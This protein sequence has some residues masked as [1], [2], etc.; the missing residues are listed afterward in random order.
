MLS[1][2]LKSLVK[3]YSF[4]C[5]GSLPFA[6][7]ERACEFV[8]SHESILPFWPELPKASPHQFMLSRSE[9]ASEP[10][11]R[12]YTKEEA[13][14]FFEFVGKMETLPVLKCQLMGPV[15]YLKYS[16]DN[17]IFSSELFQRAV[18]IAWRQMHWQRQQIPM[19]TC[20]I[21]VLDEPVIGN[22]A[23]W[24]RDEVFEGYSYLY[25]R[26]SELNSYIGVHICGK[27]SE[28]VFDL[29]VQ[30]ISYTH[31]DLCE[32]SLQSRL[33]R[34]LS[35]GGIIAPGFVPGVPPEGADMEALVQKGR[36]EY[37]RLKEAFSHY[38]S[39][40]LF[41]ADC[42]HFGADEGW[43]KAIYG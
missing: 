14:G 34:F 40:L 32:T 42:G 27:L 33:K 29:P 31:N 37:E 21:F 2:P 6:Q 30:L 43:L 15:S 25:A 17:V 38:A 3:P 28:K 22:D 9:R 26:I 20:I 35:D 8:L 7:A 4:F 5:V 10:G 18:Q 24:H 39:Q 12:G 23:Y 13:S 19:N 11:W 36:D 16:S 1:F 41:A